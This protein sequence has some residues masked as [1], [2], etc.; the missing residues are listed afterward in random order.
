M[1]NP[2]QKLRATI[3]SI[4]QEYK[5]AARKKT[6]SLETPQEKVAHLNKTVD[7]PT[8]WYGNSYG[9]FFINPAL[10]NSNSTIYSIGIGKDIT[11]DLKCI[12]KHNA[13]IFGFDPTPKSI[14]WLKTLNLPKNFKFFEFGIS[15]KE[16]GTETFFLPATKHGTSGS[17]LKTN[18]VN[19]NNSITVNMK[20]FADMT[21]EL[22]H[23]HIDVLKMDIEGAEYDVLESILNSP[24]TID[25]IL[26]EF[27]DRLFDMDIFKSTEIVAKMKSKG[28]HIFAAS[29]SWEEISFIHERKLNA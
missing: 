21:S 10:V 24:V 29:I 13:Q 19:A 8:A 1:Q 5:S 20:T 3:N 6:L 14:N 18:A 28:Y 9:G 2:L 12:E 15:A 17:L 4:R 16:S 23:K 26:V 27:H 7:C 25:Q 11:F 22:G